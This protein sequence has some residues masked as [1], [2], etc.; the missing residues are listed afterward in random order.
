M[1]SLRVADCVT[2]DNPNPRKTRILLMLALTRSE[3]PAE[4][5][6]MF[7]WYRGGRD[8]IFLAP[9][10]VTA[11]FSAPP[12]PGRFPGHQNQATLETFRS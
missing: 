7:D 11:I 12:G 3:D 4:I 1:A 9:G 5:Q 8:E 6:A 2:A 10:R